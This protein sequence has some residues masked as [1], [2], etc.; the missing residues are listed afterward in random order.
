MEGFKGLIET[1]IGFPIAVFLFLLT[2]RL[3]FSD[4]RRCYLLMARMYAGSRTENIRS[5]LSALIGL[6]LRDLVRLRLFE[7][8]MLRRVRMRVE[9][10]IFQPR[11]VF[12]WPLPEDHPDY[13]S[14]GL[15]P[16][17]G[18]AGRKRARKRHKRQLA[19]WRKAMRRIYGKGE[20]QLIR[21]ESPAQVNDCFSEIKRYFDTLKSL[22]LE[23]GDEESGDARKFAC[24][25]EIAAG[26]V[27]P[28]HLLTGLLIQFNQKWKTILTA[29]DRD[30]ND[31]RGLRANLESADLRQIQMFIYNCWLLWGPS[32][33]VCTC[34]RW[35]ARYV[36][37]Q[38]GFGDENNSI[39]LVGEREAVAGDLATMF[40]QARSEL[41]AAG[42]RRTPM[43][44][45]ATVRGRLQLSGSLKER[46]GAPSPLP[47][48]ARDSWG[49]GQ[50]ERPVLFVSETEEGDAVKGDLTVKERRLGRIMADSRAF[51]SRYY[52]AYLWVA[53]VM[54]CHDG[55]DWRPVSDDGRATEPWKDL[56]P[57]FEH[58]NLADP[59][60][61]FFSKQQLVAK[62]L[63]GIA[64]IVRDWSH[65]AVPLRF[66]YACAIDDSGCGRPLAFPDWAGGDTVRQMLQVAL[67]KK[68]A[69]GGEESAL[70]ARLASEKIV[71]FDHYTA[72]DGDHAYSACHLPI[73][74]DRHY[75]SMEA[76]G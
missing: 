66:A 46:K 58:G 49:G 62:A 47:L 33:P 27:A 4:L 70:F 34:H 44:L 56:I 8:R 52:S 54:L 26:F 13:D 69:A 32:I 67:T 64:A 7:S 31:L 38:Y 45:P 43:A 75:R 68:A 20:Q 51:K 53:F 12:V 30:A 16:L 21:I 25:M 72:A 41:T 71:L 19:E 50:D 1:Y 2:V 18:R 61:C 39:E 22:G 17:D 42:K 29:F 74:I 37:I 76:E 73:Y 59:E 9:H 10:E 65:G 5:I 15:R 11:P 36:A 63:S 3:I 6:A 14:E 57:F 35:H 60:T 28:I 55:R 40:A 23:D 24:P 48:A